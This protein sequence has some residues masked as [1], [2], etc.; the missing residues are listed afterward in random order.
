[1]SFRNS[2]LC[3]VVFSHRAFVTG[4]KWSMALLQSKNILEAFS[5]LFFSHPAW[6]MC[7]PSPTTSLSSTPIFPHWSFI[8]S[9]A[10]WWGG[11]VP[12]TWWYLDFPKRFPISCEFWLTDINKKAHNQPRLKTYSIWHKALWSLS[13]CPWFLTSCK[14]LGQLEKVFCHF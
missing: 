4:L 1:M 2:K 3:T 9:Y 8:S 14:C 10:L 13:N 6:Q 7:L 5:S 12:A 11:N